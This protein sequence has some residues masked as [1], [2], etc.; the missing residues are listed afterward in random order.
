MRSM[1]IALLRAGS[2][3]QRLKRKV[4]NSPTSACVHWYVDMMCNT[5]QIIFDVRFVRMCT[6]ETKGIDARVVR[7]VPRT[8][9][10]LDQKRRNVFRMS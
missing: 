5:D 7:E 10:T 9:E 2:S 4:R 1:K 6:S 3:C 8:E